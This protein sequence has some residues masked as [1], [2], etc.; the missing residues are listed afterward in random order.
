ML[1]N[2]NRPNIRGIKKCRF[3][4]YYNGNRSKSC[5]NENCPQ[6]LECSRR[7]TKR[8]CRVEESPLDPIT[9]N[10]RD[11]VQYFS[12]RVADKGTPGRF[13]SLVKIE[14]STIKTDSNTVIICRTAVCFVDSCMTS[15]TNCRHIVECTGQRNKQMATGV[16]I[17]RTKFLKFFSHLTEAER[18]DL[19]DYYGAS[20][21]TA[22]QQLRGNLFVVRCPVP[23]GNKENSGGLNVTSGV[24]DF[25]HCE[26]REMGRE[27][28]F[29][30]SCQGTTTFTGNNYL[31]HHLLLLYSAIDSDSCLREKFKSHLNAAC[32]Q[33]DLHELDLLEMEGNLSLDWD[34][35]ADSFL[36]DMINEEILMDQSG[37]LEFIG[38]IGDL[39][40]ETEE[41]L[42]PANDKMEK[43]DCDGNGNLN[44][45]V[46]K[47]TLS[48]SF[49]TILT[50]II[51]RMNCNFNLA[52]S[53]TTTQEFVFYV[54]NVRGARGEG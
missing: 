32:Y 29:S 12:V 51:E 39:L 7:S 46:D 30:C 8:V 24:T 10:S 33:L 42:L 3:C 19:W 25:V 1:L 2:L 40:Q 34:L 49:D 37:E 4:G 45:R 18:N 48:V 17:I 11:D 16:P 26:L 31:C 9:I 23:C 47:M 54:H 5:K 14:E 28:R 21:S 6:F 13:R 20:L 38:D 50:S 52:G 36:E 44:C 53:D 22:V 27:T 41:I 35:K 15:V 43:N